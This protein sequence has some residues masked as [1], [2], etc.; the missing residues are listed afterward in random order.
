M[1]PTDHRHSMVPLGHVARLHIIYYNMEHMPAP[2][3]SIYINLYKRR[4][5]GGRKP[6]QPLLRTFLGPAAPDP[7][8]PYASYRLHAVALRP[9]SISTGLR[10]TAPLGNT[11]LR[12]L[13]GGR[14]AVCGLLT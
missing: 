4:G 6:P 1:G 3:Y 12:G 14:A 8:R 13:S 5:V 7:A 11:I 2:I 10:A 9:E